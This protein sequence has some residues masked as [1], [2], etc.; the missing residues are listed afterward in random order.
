LKSSLN[1]HSLIVFFTVHPVLVLLL[2]VLGKVAHWSL[3]IGLLRRDLLQILRLLHGL[4]V[5]AGAWAIL[6]LH[7]GLVSVISLVIIKFPVF[8]CR[9]VFI[10]LLL[11][12]RSVAHFLLLHDFLVL[13]LTEL[14]LLVD[15][16]ELQG[17]AL[18]LEVLPAEVSLYFVDLATEHLLCTLDPHCTGWRLACTDSFGVATLLG[19]LLLQGVLLYL[20]VID[21]LN[22]RDILLENA[23]V[24]FLM[25]FLVVVEFLAKSPHIVFQ[26]LAHHI[27]LLVEVHGADV[28]LRFLQ[29][30]HL[31][32]ANHC[33]L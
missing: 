33:F 11:S 7:I 4:A 15:V 10:L 23:F 1:L 28:L 26:M 8:T 21:F 14:V 13:L 30:P 5:Q 32:Q 17:Q 24:F 22:K 2:F 29:N 20:Q 19:D 9:N 6:L 12:V 16:L 31:V 25:V 27:V 3:T 18:N